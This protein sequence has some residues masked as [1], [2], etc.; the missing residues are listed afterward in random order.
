[1]ELRHA[2]INNA[3]QLFPSDLVAKA[4]V[5]S[6]CALHDETIRKVIS[7]DKWPT[8]TLSKTKPKSQSSRPV[9]S[10]IKLQDSVQS[11]KAL[12]ARK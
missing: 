7:F 4:D 11:T 1:M 8:Q 5:K 3:L 9:S 12:S 6:S 2:P 10:S